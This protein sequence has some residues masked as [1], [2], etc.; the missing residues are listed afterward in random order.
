MVVGVTPQGEDILQR[1][2]VDITQRKILQEQLER[3]QE[4]YRVSMEVSSAIM[5]E[6]RM[7]EDVF[8]SYEPKTGQ[9]VL[10]KRTER[11]L[12]DATERQVV[13]PDD[14]PTVI[15]NIC[16]GR[17]EVFEVRMSVPG[18]EPGSYIWHRVNSRLMMENGK[19]S[20]VVGALHNIHSM[21]AKLSE[22]SERLYM[23]QSALQAI[24]GVYVSI[25]YVN[26]PEDSYYAVRL[27]EARSGAVLPR[28]GCYSTDLCSYILSDVDQAD[29]NRVM[30]ICGR[31][32]AF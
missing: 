19:P 20:R 16:N 13:H 11:L 6:Y 29:R 26:L 24:N 15:D 4:M 27:P 10:R 3:E 32:C 1:T 5:F 28:N 2:A 12:Q 23:S 31:G 21:K 17:S 25:F 30:S 8:I 22:N 18:G 9:G 14:V 7:D